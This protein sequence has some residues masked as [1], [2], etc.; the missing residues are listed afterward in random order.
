[1]RGRA[2]NGCSRYRTIDKTRPELGAKAP[3]IIL[4]VVVFLR[5][6]DQQSN[7]STCF[8]LK[9]GS[10]TARRAAKLRLRRSARIMGLRSSQ[11]PGLTAA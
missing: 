10:W 5:H 11:T 7:N 3:V 4:K 1:M 9:S 2:S 8:K 6:L